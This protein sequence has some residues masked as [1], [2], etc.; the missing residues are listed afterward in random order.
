MIRPAPRLKLHRLGMAYVAFRVAGAKRWVYFGP[1]G[2]Q[3]ARAKYEAFVRRWPAQ[4]NEMAPMGKWPAVRLLTFRGRTLSIARWA[5][6]TGL[7]ATT[8]RYRLDRLKW[9][10]ER[11]LTIPT[12]TS[13][14]GTAG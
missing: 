12:R 6:E 4:L 14:I 13:A 10:V 11:A 1:F 7:K 8:I 3:A 5:A 9:T 2:S